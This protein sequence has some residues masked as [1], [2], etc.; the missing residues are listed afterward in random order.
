MSWLSLV[1][2]SCIDGLPS[3]VVLHYF[4]CY[5]LLLDSRCSVLISVAPINASSNHLRIVRYGFVRLLLLLVYE[6]IGC[7]DVIVSVC[8]DTFGGVIMVKLM[9]FHDDLVYVRVNWHFL[10]AWEES[11]HSLFLHLLEPRMTPNVFYTVSCFWVSVK[12]LC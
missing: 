2:V 9:L 12:D 4:L 6:V 10:F 8:F 7:S 5:L 1:K 3:L 11:S